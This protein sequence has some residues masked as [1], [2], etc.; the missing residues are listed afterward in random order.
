MVHDRI[1]LNQTYRVKYELVDAVDKGKNK[2][3]VLL[4]RIEAFAV[5]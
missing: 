2:G 5:D 1:K 3:A 4:E